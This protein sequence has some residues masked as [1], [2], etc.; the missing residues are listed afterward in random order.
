[1]NHA[2]NMSA[3][4]RQQRFHHSTPVVQ[5]AFGHCQ[6]CDIVHHLPTTDEARVAALAL[7]KEI[8]STGRIDFDERVG[9]TASYYNSTRGIPSSS[10]V[11]PL[12]SRSLID[13]RGKM[14]GVLIASDPTSGEKVTLKSFAGA[15]DGYWLVPGWAPPL[16]GTTLDDV[17]GYRAAS[18]AVALLSADLA[19]A[20]ARGER[21][22]AASIKAERTRLSRLGGL[23][24]RRATRV[25]NFRGQEAELAAVYNHL[26][27]PPSLWQGPRGR[28]RATGGSPDAA[29]SPPQPEPPAGLGHCAAAKL[30]AWAS[31]RG[32]RPL[33]VAEV[34]VGRQARSNGSINGREAGDGD[35]HDACAPR[36]Q[37]VMGFMLCGLGRP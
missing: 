31:R 4:F 34:F 2:K 25:V 33:S 19:A 30:V 5:A 13:R 37:P 17:P 32:L 36:C 35:L 15:V 21:G 26:S 22:Q 12:S 16:F 6:R 3:I 20:E 7:R 8:L 29:E 28:A 23:A 24:V 27:S 9:A 11:S 10:V 1:M 14:F 18:E